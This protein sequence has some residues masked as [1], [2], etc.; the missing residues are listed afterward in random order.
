MSL[1]KTRPLGDS[2]ADGPVSG[3]ATQ[4]S[5][6]SLSI[7]AKKLLIASP[8]AA[9]PAIGPTPPAR[10]GISP[11]ASTRMSAKLREATPPRKRKQF[12][13]TTHCNRRQFPSQFPQHSDPARIPPA[14][15]TLPE[16][17]MNDPTPSRPYWPDFA[18]MPKDPSKGLKPW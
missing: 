9:S 18:D 16:A 2:S 3:C 4:N 7:A 8:A 14:N 6:S 11:T 13:T 15:W 17:F 12:R 1:E 10:F 5:E